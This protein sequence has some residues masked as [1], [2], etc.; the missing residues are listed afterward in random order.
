M[1]SMFKTNIAIIFNGE[2]EREELEKLSMFL[3]ADPDVED[4]TFDTA[5]VVIE[6]NPEPGVLARSIDCTSLLITLGTMFDLM[7]KWR[8]ERHSGGRLE[9]YREE[10]PERYIYFYII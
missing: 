3:K 7:F 10:G 6:E 9:R 5:E 2:L 1:E 4:F 8:F